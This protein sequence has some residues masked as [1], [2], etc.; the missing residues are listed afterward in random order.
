M[1]L[2]SELRNQNSPISKWFEEKYHQGVGN[3]IN[4]HN[5][6]MKHSSIIKPTEGTNFPLVGIAITYGLRKFIAQ[7]KDDK[8]WVIN[9]IAGEASFKLGLSELADF[10]S[11]NDSS[12]KDE[13]L[14]LLVLGGLENYYRS[15]RIHEI[16][17]PFFYNNKKLSLSQEFINQWMPSIQDVCQI[18]EEIPAIWQNFDSI[19][20]ISENVI[21]NATFYLSNYLPADCQMIIGNAIIDIR[22]T[23]KKQPFTLNNLYQQLSYLLFDSNNEYDINKLVWIYPRQKILFHYSTDKLFKNIHAT[24]IEFKQMVENN[25]GYSRSLLKY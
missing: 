10:C 2:T 13:A 22:T 17:Q 21:S 1:S 24:R 11:K 4:H 9:T 25:Y 16:I 20:D 12:E 8:H 15:G 19:I 5:Q 3:I 7:K 23:A 6:M 18:M 14:K